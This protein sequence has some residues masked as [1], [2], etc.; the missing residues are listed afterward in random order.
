MVAD[1]DIWNQAD[2]INAERTTPTRLPAIQQPT[3]AQV[4]LATADVLVWLAMNQ[5]PI[6]WLTPILIGSCAALG[7]HMLRRTRY[8]AA[9]A[10]AGGVVGWELALILGKPTASA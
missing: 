8:L 4:A 6:G 2:T 3:Q 9:G 5:G 7:A 1:S 10:F